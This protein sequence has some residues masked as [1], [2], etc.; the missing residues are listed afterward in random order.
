MVD[1]FGAQDGNITGL[2][3]KLVVVLK[4]RRPL[5]LGDALDQ[6]GLGAGVEAAVI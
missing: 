6:V 1:H 4:Q 2:V 5:K 3:G